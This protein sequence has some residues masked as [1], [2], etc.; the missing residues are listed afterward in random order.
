MA[1]LEERIDA[2]RAF[3]RFYTRLIGALQDAYLGEQFSLAEA[4]VIYE[5]ATGRAPGGAALRESLGLDPGYFSRIIQRLESLGVVVRARDKIDRRRA[6]ITLTPRGHGA[7]RRLDKSVR[8]ELGRLLGKLADDGQEDVVDAMRRIRASLDGSASQVMLRGPDPGDVGWVIARH[9]ALYAEEY[10]YDARFE[11][12]AGKVAS[13]FLLAHDPARERG[14]IA[15]RDG[16]R[17]GCVFLMREDETA[18]RLRLLLVEPAARG[19]GLGRRLTETC[20]GFAREAGYARI[21]LWTNEVLTAARAIY[22]KL[23]FRLVKSTPHAMFGPP[24]VGEDWVLDLS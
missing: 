4:R 18:A 1:P 15:V 23:G 13:G 5:L 12:L 14:W 19:I 8:T 21:V 2:I 20:V 24:S 3:N 7:F 22:A 11:G 9:G 17:V 6:A 10:G 16:V